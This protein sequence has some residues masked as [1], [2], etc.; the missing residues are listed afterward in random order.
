MPAAECSAKVIAQINP[1]VPRTHGHSFIH[2]NAF[3]YV[4][5]VGGN[6]LA[7]LPELA[8]PEIGEAD[9]AIGRVIAELIP[10]GACLQV[11]IGAIPNAVLSYLKNHRYLGIH[12]EMFSDGVMDL[13]Q[14]G[15]VDNTQKSF[16]QG[17]T[18]TAFLV[19]SRELYDFVND[20][21][22]IHLDEASVTNSPVIISRNKKV[23]AINSAL[24]VDLTGQVCADSV[25]TRMI[26]G[27]GGQ[28]DF[29]R[30]A[31]LSDGGFPIIC[32]RSTTK[33]HQSTI[34]G[35]LKLGAGITTSRY[36]AHWIVTEF[37]AVNLWGKDLVERARAMISIA[38]PDH[39]E[40]L[41]REAFDR[42]KVLV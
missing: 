39:R 1:N 21:P 28:L 35:T 29:V 36:H 41:A 19:G 20:N 27:V 2:V 22:G 25:G 13:L 10:D 24:E 23:V 31:A 15:A 4:V 16:L 12:S 40:S 26:S 37:G 3:D 5:D 11:G 14:S 18:V 32:L 34:V 9:M 7:L 33:K 17:R 42:F 6:S 30:G 38:H 8:V